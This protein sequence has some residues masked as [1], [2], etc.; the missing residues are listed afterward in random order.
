MQTKPQYRIVLAILFSSDPATLYWTSIL[1]VYWGRRFSIDRSFQFLFEDTVH[2]AT[3]KINPWTFE[4]IRRLPQ[5]KLCWGA[6]LAIAMELVL[7][8]L[9]NLP[10]PSGIPRI[11]PHKQWLRRH[12]PFKQV[13][14]GSPR[15][16]SA[17]VSR[18]SLWTYP[19]ELTGS[20]PY[21]GHNLNPPVEFLFKIFHGQKI[22]NRRMRC[23]TLLKAA[24][25]HLRKSD[26]SIK[27]VRLAQHSL[28]L[29]ALWY[30]KLMKRARA[31]MDAYIWRWNSAYSFSL[32]CY[33]SNID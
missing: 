25:S 1:L 16:A 23:L 4:A 26:C 29:A 9:V 21:E 30:P 17:L 24:I 8:Q 18:F 15:L 10:K 14:L 27:V 28:P 2:D 13:A 22:H 7:L 31:E 3:G 6:D 12:K 5:S 11:T 33:F 19:D 32:F 20:T